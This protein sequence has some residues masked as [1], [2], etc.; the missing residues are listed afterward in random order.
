MPAFLYR[1]Q[2]L[3]GCRHPSSNS[4]GE[5]W[6]TSEVMYH[7]PP[8]PPNV[9]YV[10]LLFEGHISE[11]A[12]LVTLGRGAD[13][14]PVINYYGEGENSQLEQNLKSTVLNIGL[15]IRRMVVRILPLSETGNG[16]WEAPCT[17][18]GAKM[19]QDDQG[20]RPMM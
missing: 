17:E 16:H 3:Y 8:Q 1:L 19:V 13:K 2:L 20:K 10:L 14:G 12:L 15:A 18:L 6:E 11:Y 7:A 5:T 4:I 9:F